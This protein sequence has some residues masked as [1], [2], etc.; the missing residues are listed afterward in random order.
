ME[1]WWVHAYGHKISF[2]NDENIL[3]LDYR[4][5]YT[6]DCTLHRWIFMAYK[7]HLNKTFQK[8]SMIDKTAD[9]TQVKRELVPR[10]MIWSI[11]PGC[12]REIE[13]EIWYEENTAFKERMPENLP[14]LLKTSILRS[15]S[16]MNLKKHK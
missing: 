7:L 9:S 12:N 1:W 13:M 8:T 14:E 3:L 6:P 11:Y 10:K 16:P 15:K 4:N 5:G 2:G